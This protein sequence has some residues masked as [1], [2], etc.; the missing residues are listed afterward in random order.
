M[1]VQL[2]SMENTASPATCMAS[3]ADKSI[4][5]IGLSSGQMLLV[6]V[7][8][9]AEPGLTQ[10]SPESLAPVSFTVSEEN[11]LEPGRNSNAALAV[12]TLPEQHAAA[13]TSATLS[14]DNRN[15][16]TVSAS[17]GAVFVWDTLPGSVSDLYVASR[18][19]I[20]GASCAVW[21]PGRRLL[22]GSSSLHLVVSPRTQ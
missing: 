19:T 14:L 15:L 20:A 4:A 3:C 6:S 11:S 16:A 8:S 18:A 2:T 10:S 17:D 5:A 12:V 9:Q 21:L 1:A 7:N 13:V 22:V